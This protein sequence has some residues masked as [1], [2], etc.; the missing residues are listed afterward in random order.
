ME[1]AVLSA[2]IFDLEVCGHAR[3]YLKTKSAIKLR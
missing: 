2:L 3:S 1:N